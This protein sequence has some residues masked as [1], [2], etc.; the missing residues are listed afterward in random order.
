MQLTHLSEDLMDKQD[1][2]HHQL[3]GI[4]KFCIFQTEKTLMKPNC[5]EM[6][7]MNNCSVIACKTLAT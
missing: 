1:K 3:H 2:V 6:Q 5:H 4:V 7:S